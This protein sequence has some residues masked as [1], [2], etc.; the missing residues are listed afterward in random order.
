MASLRVGDKVKYLGPWDPCGAY[1]FHPYQGKIAQVTGI[2]TVPP[3]PER[4]IVIRFSDG[5]VERATQLEV[6]PV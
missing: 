6:Q 2:E 3:L 5:T 1:G 4:P